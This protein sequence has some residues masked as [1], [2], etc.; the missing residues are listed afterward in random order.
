M[1]VFVFAFGP[2]YLSL[3]TRTSLSP[4][5]HDWSLYGP[6]PIGFCVANVPVG[7]NWP[8]APDGSLV[9]LVLLERRRAGDPEVRERE[10]AQERRRATGEDDP[11]GVLARCLAAAIEGLVRPVATG[12]RLR[13][14][15]EDGVPVVADVVALQ[16]RPGGTTSG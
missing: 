9:R 13:V 8:S 14:A 10:R 15:A 16:L 6:V 4:I 1:T 2:Q 7:R 12:S 11:H 5:L 3:R